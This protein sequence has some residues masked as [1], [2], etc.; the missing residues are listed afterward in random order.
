MTFDLHLSQYHNCCMAVFVVICFCCSLI[1]F[2][3]LVT[4]LPP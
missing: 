2:T 4:R 1:F 3:I